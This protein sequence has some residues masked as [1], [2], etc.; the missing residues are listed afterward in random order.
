MNGL[1]LEKKFGGLS[2]AAIFKKLGWEVTPSTPPSTP[3][4]SPPTKKHQTK[5]TELVEKWKTNNAAKKA[6]SHENNTNNGDSKTTEKQQSCDNEHTAKKARHED[7][8]DAKK[9][10]FW[11]ILNV[12]AYRCISVSVYQ[13]TIVVVMAILAA[14]VV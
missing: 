13:Y 3:T 1:A 8:K 5:T 9:E 2:A 11:C 7:N 12:R 14:F 6:R 10:W 4:N